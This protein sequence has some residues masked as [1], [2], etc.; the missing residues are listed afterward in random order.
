[1]RRWNYS[2]ISQPWRSAY[3]VDGGPANIA[4]FGWPENIERSYTISTARRAASTQ[5]ASAT[6]TGANA[7]DNTAYLLVARDEVGKRLVHDFLRAG[8]SGTGAFYAVYKRPV[9]DRPARIALQF[10]PAGALLSGKIAMKQSCSYAHRIQM[11]R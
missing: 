10:S 6:G 8:N 9:F 5:S 3:L 11:E 4:L 2:S 7:G 1:V